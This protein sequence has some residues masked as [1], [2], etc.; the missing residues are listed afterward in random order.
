M[1][2]KHRHLSKLMETNLILSFVSKHWSMNTITD[3]VN[4]WNHRL[5]P[6]KVK[7]RRWKI[8]NDCKNC[9]SPSRVC[10]DNFSPRTTVV[11][12]GKEL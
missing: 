9:F 1:L 6:E 7:A 8:Q 2:I 10:L 3:G 11:G 12:G 5:E 4:I